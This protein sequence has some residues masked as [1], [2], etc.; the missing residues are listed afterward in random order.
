MAAFSGTDHVVDRLNYSLSIKV[1]PS[2][3]WGD[4]AIVAQ[5]A[6]LRHYTYK[7]KTQRIERLDGIERVFNPSLRLLIP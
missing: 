4:K 3:S 6:S 1:R 7:P 5:P 2:T